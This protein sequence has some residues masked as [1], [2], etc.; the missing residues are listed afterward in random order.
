MNTKHLLT[1]AIFVLLSYSSF[2][3]TLTDNSSKNYTAKI[4][5]T[6]C[7]DD[8]CN[9]AIKLYKKNSKTVFQEF[10]SKEFRK[11]ESGETN[12][13]FDDFNFDGTEDVAIQNGYGGYGAASYDVYVYNA[14]KK[15]F[16]KSTELTK[17]ASQQGM[18]VLD[19]DQKRIKS[20]TKSGCCWH[21]EEHYKVVPNKGLVMVYNKVEDAT[22]NNDMVSVTEKKLV[23]HKWV[24]STKKH[25]T[26]DYYKD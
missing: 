18:F 19:K 5:L 22:K 26:K 24:T 25:K 12:L 17:L 16:V 11:T 3:Q 15:Q 2:T 20:F 10:K 8:N 13:I 9:A 23:N 1:S 4:T 6:K 7:Q 21:K 14:T